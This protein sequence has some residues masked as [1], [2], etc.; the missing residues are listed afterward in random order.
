MK[1]RIFLGL[2][3]TFLVLQVFRPTKNLCATA[4]FT[5]PNDITVLYPPPAEVRQILATSCYDCHSN[6]TRYPW[7]AEIQPVGWWLASHVTDARRQLNF[8]EFG[9]LSRKRQMKRLE[10]I[11][12]EVRDRTMPL[13]SYTYIH[14]EAKLTDAQISALCNWAEGIQEKLEG[15]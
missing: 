15:Q 14:R 10:S 1:T 3:V 5:G 7:Y 12:D 2:M 6:Q 13:K 4:P 8:A 9:A 11:V